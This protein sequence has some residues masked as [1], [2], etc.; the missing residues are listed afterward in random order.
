MELDKDPGKDVSTRIPNY[1]RPATAVVDLLLTASV[2]LWVLHL[3]KQKTA[4]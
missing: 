2:A 3:K 1:G 4:E